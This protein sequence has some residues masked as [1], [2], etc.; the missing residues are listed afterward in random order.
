MPD[1]PNDKPDGTPPD[2]T[3]PTGDPPKP[4]ATQDI[5]TLKVH[6]KDL[7][8]PVAEIDAAAQKWLADGQTM[9]GN[10]K[11]EREH[12]QDLEIAKAFRAA[13]SG[14]DMD[15][16]R[17]LMKLGGSSDADVDRMVAFYG[18]MTTE[19]G[20]DGN[21]AGE[22]GNSPVAPELTSDAVLKVLGLSKDEL[23]AT[24]SFVR[25]LRAQKLDPGKVGEILGSTVNAESDKITRRYLKDV[26]VKDQAVQRLQTLR[27]SI[28]SVVEIAMPYLTA[29]S[30][31]GVALT[32]EDFKVAAGQ[33]IAT[34]KSVMPERALEGAPASLGSLGGDDGV[35]FWPEGKE[36][37]RPD[38]NDQAKFEAWTLRRLAAGVSAPE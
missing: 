5:R 17:K 11:I 9:E 31:P 3:P 25:E 13:H 26:L 8:M 15:A 4:D 19:D 7:E 2:G 6:G 23:G 12:A 33:A 18:E 27:G 20:N 24:M 36:D 35:A 29:R 10:K 32:D 1:D 34:V 38:V 16:Y 22:T 37:P 14:N 30:K 21:D 28:D